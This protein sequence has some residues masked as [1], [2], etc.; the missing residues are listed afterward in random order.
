MPNIDSDLIRGNIDTI[1]LKTMVDQDMYGLDIIKEVEAKSN[2]TYELKQPTLYSCLKRLE[3]Q[4]LI[5]SYWVDSDIGGRR[6]YYKLTDKGRETLQKKQEEWLKSKFIIDNLLS[7]HDYDEYRL[8]NKEDYDKIIEGKQFEYKPANENETTEADVENTEE[9]ESENNQ[10]YQSNV[11]LINSLKTTL[12]ELQDDNETQ[13]IVEDEVEE[14]QENL[15]DE[16]Q[17]SNETISD[18]PAQTQPYRK[19]FL[20]MDDEENQNDEAQSLNETEPLEENNEP[21]ELEEVAETDAENE[22]FHETD[23]SKELNQESTNEVENDDYEVVQEEFSTETADSEEPSTEL[24]ETDNFK[25]QEAFSYES[26]SYSYGDYE[27]E[28]QNDNYSSETTFVQNEDHSE[29]EK[30]IL[31]KLRHDEEVNEYVGENDSYTSIYGN[32]NV[33]QQ[34]ILNMDLGKSEDEVDDKID[35]FSYAIDELNNFSSEGETTNQGLEFEEYVPDEEHA[36]DTFN[37][38]TFVAENEDDENY[39]SELDNINDENSASFFNSSEVGYD[40]SFPSKEENSHE[41]TVQTVEN[42]ELSPT[43]TIE[44]DTEETENNEVNNFDDIIS[45]SAANYKTENT[46]YQNRTYESFKPSYTGET[47]KQKLSNLSEYS[48]NQNLNAEEPEAIKKSKDIA[49]LKKEFEQEGI[50]IKTYQKST[51]FEVEKNYLLI[52]KLNLVKSLILLFGY[53][54]VLSAL[55]IILNN[56]GAREM[57]GF[58]IKF[59]LFGFIPFV[60]YA[61]YY[62]VLYIINPYKKIPAKFAPRIVT[63]ISVIITVQLLLITYCVNLQLGFYS[64]SQSLYNHLYWIIPAIISFAPVISNVIFMSLFYSKNFNV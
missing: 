1:I 10:D 61:G 20:D 21:V 3:N 2:G 16:P 4:E 47:Y 11:E 31:S 17:E 43:T 37:Q 46:E 49:T 42:V 6:H 36:E 57:T 15:D 29:Q 26:P 8:V 55:Y 51:S 53:V 38:Q 39:L 27:T 62:A 41:K 32:Q 40:E 45:K 7:N 30:N 58:H 14:D 35:Q 22:E 28:N 44:N 52:N 63:F 56:T 60:I 33:E 18:S 9:T 12:S 5:S 59:F 25:D 13:E 24:N 54:F 50:K 19:Y 34:N 23:E 64:F 48:K